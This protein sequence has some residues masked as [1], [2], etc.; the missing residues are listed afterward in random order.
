MKKFISPFL[1]ISVILI[2]G[3]VTFED[4]GTGVTCVDPEKFIEG[5]CC[6]DEDDSGVCDID[7]REC[8]ESCD[9]SDSCTRDYC[10]FETGFECKH[11]PIK[12]C[13]GNGVC[14]ESEDVA[15][16][17]PEDCT[18]I[19]IT[20]FHHRY[21]GPDY[22][23]DDTFVFIHTGSNLTDKRPDFYL[24]ITAGSTRIIN[25]QVTYNC[26]DSAT[27]HKVD[28]INANRI[29]VVPGYPTFGHWK[30]FDNDAYNSDTFF[31]SQE[32]G[33]KI[34]VAELGVGKTVEFRMDI[35]RKDYK[36]RS[37][38][39]CDFDFYFLEPLKRVR[40]QLKISYI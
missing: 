35:S 17:C 15:N 12:P 10:S 33:Y 1:V 25:I 16:E 37:K 7:E 40:K 14:E 27:G 11:D 26:T 22:M 20:E 9:D 34:E 13:C 30:E 3:C 2:A 24:N 18:V 32:L 23:D 38:M 28:S 31:Y 19:D 21:G 4:Q 39:N 29:E 5:R 36:A 6:F 8:P